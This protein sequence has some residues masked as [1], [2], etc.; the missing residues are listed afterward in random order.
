MNDDEARR[1]VGWV[2]REASRLMGSSA[3]SP[4]EWATYYERKAELLAYLG[5]PDL[6]ARAES[7]A[8]SY[9]PGGA[10]YSPAADR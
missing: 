5:E 4:E 10:F 8:A 6:A 3:A 9:R 2:A 7:Q 1:E